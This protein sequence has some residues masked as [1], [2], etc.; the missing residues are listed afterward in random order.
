MRFVED[1]PSIPDE[2][3]WA[4]DQGRVVFFCGAGVSRAR[5]QLPDFF[6]LA[7]EVI[8]SLGVPKDSP[9]CRLVEEA[10]EI[11][12]RV[13][14]A[15]VISADR[16]FGL[17]ERE[18]LGRDIEAAVASALKPSRPCDLSAHR[19]LLDLA[20]TTEG[21][22]RLVTTNF[23]RLFDECGR[24]LQTWQ[25]PRLPD[26]RRAGEL[27][28]IV[29][30]HGRATEAYDGAEGDGFVLSSSDFGRAYLADGWATEFFQS[31]LARFVVVFVGYAAD[32]PPVQYLLEALN[33]VPGR[34]DH[35]YA[36]QSGGEADAAARW[37]HKGVEAIAYNDSNGHAAL[38]RTLEAWSARA[39]D[40]DGWYRDVIR[41]SQQ[42][43]EALA[44]HER[45]Q[46]AHV[47]SSYEG[48][49]RFAEEEIPPPAEW[50]CV[51]DP[52][53][54][55][56]KPGHLGTLVEKGEYVD[57]FD[58]YGL[59]SDFIPDKPEPDEHN[60]RRE[61]PS[62][63]WDAF[64]LNRIDRQALRDDNFPALRGHWARNAP[65]LV[66]RI[67]V[68]SHWLTRVSDQ[69]ASV[70]WAGHQF[71]LHPDIRDRIRWQLERAPQPSKPEIRKAW[72]YLF[73]SWDSYRG[74]FHRDIFEL[75][76][77][78]AKDGW[79]SAAVR[80]YSSI[81]QPYFEAQSNYWGGPKPPSAGADLQVGDLVRMDVKYPEKHE[82]IEIPDEW[83]AQTVKALSRNL[84]MA[85]LLE[86][87]I[88]GY[89]LMAICPILADDNV[90]DDQ[91]ERNHGLGSHI[92]EYAA[93]LQR[94]AEI[95]PQAAKFE[96]HAWGSDDPVFNRLRIWAMGNNTLVP[97]D[98][99]LRQ[100]ELLPDE[101][102][103]GSRDQRDLLLSLKRRWNELSETVQQRIE[104][105]IVAGPD[106]W[107]NEEEQEFIERSAFAVLNR[108][109]W[110]E[111]QGCSLRVDLRKLS[112]ELQ[113][114]ASKWKPEYS[115]SAA[116]SLEGRVG[117]VRTE[118][119]TS[120]LVS[121]PLSAILA[122][123]KELS[124]RSEEFVERSPFSGLVEEKPVRA[125]AAL[126]L[127][128]KNGEYPEWA[129]RTFLTAETRKRDS[130]RFVLLTASRLLSYPRKD[131]SGLIYPL[132]EWALNVSTALS[133]RDELVFFKVVGRIADIIRADPT[134]GN[135]AII[136]GT[137]DHD[138]ATEA[139]NAPAGKI[140]Q[141]LFNAPSTNGLRKGQGLPENWLKHANALLAVGGE[142]RCHA[143]VIFCHNLVWF[144]FV[145]PEWT[146]TNFLPVLRNDSGDDRDAAWAGFF[147]AA[148]IPPPS[149]YRKLKGA[150]M[151]IATTNA[152]S[153]RSH[154]QVLAGML[155]VGWAAL[156][157]D[158]GQPNI[159]ND[160]MRDL[161]LKSDE[162][163]RSHVLWQAE[164]WAENEG[165]QAEI[166]WS[167]KIEALLEDVWPRQILAK[168][169]RISARL[170]NFV[171]SDKDRF[172]RRVAI[173]LPLLSKAEGDS[174][175]LPNLRKS[176]DNIVDIY[177]E[178]TLA[179]LDAILP[180]NAM[181]WPY[182]IESTIE[183]I[184]KADGR[185]NADP[186]LLSLKR[187]WDAR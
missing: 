92:I 55:Y 23:D 135:S 158:T 162:E 82:Q 181:A 122:K 25:P 13:G 42:G 134:C 120:G 121:V 68:L 129:W 173:V 126:H 20:T 168:T 185:L 6:G 75:K 86:K 40:V 106:R 84:E 156:D 32:D 104:E 137:G 45:G 131:V 79:D 46:V 41:M 140:A 167:E 44:P 30:L 187:R 174:I 31:I 56:A 22:V 105:R 39:R 66:P 160:E 119:D 111:G 89:G 26:P 76:A 95:N 149:L 144:N 77:Q 2:L 146:E 143:L 49:K 145:A 69:A 161:L 136:R 151:R 118:K 12:G 9:A 36:L 97:M 53:R 155:L 1:G 96:V 3:L 21:V 114:R 153:K 14:V 172:V 70:W 183:R 8:T 61:V 115:A 182:G 5:A 102:F 35:V 103:W 141:A 33:K 62:G 123:A 171:F 34:L 132:S 15:G 139:L 100:A 93:L 101:A 11:D 117:W 169:P 90:G 98:D 184:G 78:I 165:E 128:A 164:R 47:V 29:Y 113:R 108:L 43:P 17:L 37:R 87:E 58:L 51:F 159:S 48:A 59:D 72:R 81:R 166:R 57:P 38:W 71:A 148:K 138:W 73:E 177:P 186:R 163:F 142:P 4:R 133:Q 28:G 127:V 54:R 179:I 125:L 99:F 85:V 74:E 83:L 64:A 180:E 50:L 147:W 63:S 176:K 124:G 80:Q 60:V 112:E 109:H 27:N 88:G 94:L 91:Y 130:P 152:T 110:L 7:K 116:A 18:F 24:D 175:M 67:S 157:P 16:V 154:E 107:K 178:Q 170:C 10:R 52:Y 150:L 65:R 19:V